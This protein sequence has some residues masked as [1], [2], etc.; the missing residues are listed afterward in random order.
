MNL[1]NTARRS[2]WSSSRLFSR[3]SSS[4]NL[5]DSTADGDEEFLRG[6]FLSSIAHHRAKLDR[7]VDDDFYVSESLRFFFAHRRQR[8]N[9]NNKRPETA[10]RRDFVRLSISA[11]FHPR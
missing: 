9:N 6:L 11:H 2:F 1:H 4:V 7:C 3:E 10:S 5:L 8:E